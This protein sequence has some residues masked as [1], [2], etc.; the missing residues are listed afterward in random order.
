[1]QFT[2]IFDLLADYFNFVVDFLQSSGLESYALSGSVDSKLFSF[3]VVGVVL[4]Y[5]IGKIR[6]LP[7]YPGASPNVPPGP[8]SQPPTP[9]TVDTISL[10][11][12]TLLSILFGVFYHWYMKGYAWA[13]ELPVRGNIKD[14]LNALLALNAFFHPFN[15]LWNRTLLW[16]K[17]RIATRPPRPVLILIIVLIGAL[18]VL[19][20]ASVYYLA[21]AIAILHGLG[22]RQLV[23]V[24]VSFSL[25]SIVLIYALVG[26]LMWGDIF[27]RKAAA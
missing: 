23:G 11:A 9:E 2:D 26:A 10:G 18:I 13:F 17:A 3:F 4:A 14:T 16:L 19:M 6:D 5:A 1:M 7:S 15:A 25:L 27:P 8:A 12:F 24:V 21:W 22:V 20:L